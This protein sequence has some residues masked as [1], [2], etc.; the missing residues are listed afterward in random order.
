MVGIKLEAPYGIHLIG[1]NY[2]V[3]D[4]VYQI[5]VWV[6]KSSIVIAKSTLKVSHFCSKKVMYNKY[7]STQ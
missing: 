2:F 1:P 5:H 6:I 3:N 7:H 4:I